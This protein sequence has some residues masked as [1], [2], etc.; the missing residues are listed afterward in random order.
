MEILTGNVY[1]VSG[2]DTS[3]PAVLNR[4]EAAGISFAGNPDVHV[5]SYTTF[6][7]DD[8]LE[9]RERAQLR[10]V[11]GG[12]RTFVIHA[13]AMTTEAQNALLKTLE[14]PPAD[15]LLFF[16]VP[17][18]ETLLPT[19]RSRAQMLDVGPSDSVSLTSANKF[20]AAPANERLKIVEMLLEKDESD[21]RDVGAIFTFLDSLEKVLSVRELDARNAEA[22]RA[23]YRARGYLGDKGALIKPLLES[24]AL[25]V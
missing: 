18:P 24:V 2:N 5:R 7:I 21:K 16:I 15:A 14:E 17:S 20:L 11:R 19:I 25:L 8:A 1:L 13:A 22:L 4:V 10:P 12:M 9:L 3:I 6:G 23:I